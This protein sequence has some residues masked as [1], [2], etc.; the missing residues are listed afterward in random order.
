MN[1]PERGREKAER[2]LEGARAVLVR[3][4]YSGATVSRVAEAAGVSRGLLHYYFKNKEELLARVL[5]ANL[6]INVVLAKEIFE[7]SNSAR[8]LARNFR[9]TLKQLALTNP[10]QFTLFFM[11][12]MISRHSETVRGELGS[13]YYE[14]RHAMREGLQVW[15]DRG[16][17]RPPMPSEGVAAM[18]AAVLD[19]ISLQIM[20]VPG[21]LED[22][23]TWESLERA[24][25]VL[26]GGSAEA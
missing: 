18:L 6:E 12:L 15:V 13:L 11:G 20:T 7:R 14:F 4:G 1:E 3:Y 8:A 21:V 22:D 24:I 25:L 9:T 2:I 5:R 16:V 19:G 26:V 10:D 17:I 23:L